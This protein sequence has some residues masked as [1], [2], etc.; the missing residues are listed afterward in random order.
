MLKVRR[1]KK[2]GKVVMSCLYIHKSAMDTL[3][4]KKSELVSETL[5]I[6]YLQEKDF[7][8]DIIKIDL[9]NK[10]VSYI[11]SLDWDLSSEPSVGRSCIVSADGKVSFREPSNLIYHH[12]WYFVKEDYSGFDVH[13][14]RRWSNYWENHAAVIKLKEDKNEKFKSKIGRREYWKERV[15][16]VVLP[17]YKAF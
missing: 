3:S 9:K 13:E 8:Y 17:D 2:V 7:S 14:A 6:L 11:Q 1:D 10:R 4:Q 15:L 5:R 12:R 16:D